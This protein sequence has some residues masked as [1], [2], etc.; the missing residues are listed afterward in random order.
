MLLGSG[1]PRA[2][3]T[4]PSSSGFASSLNTSTLP[5]RSSSTR[6]TKMK[7]RNAKLAK[8]AL[9]V[10][11]PLPV[12]EHFW[13]SVQKEGPNILVLDIETSPMLGM[14]FGMYDQSLSL[15]HVLQHSGIL[16]YCGMW[17]HD[18]EPFYQ[19]LRGRDPYDDKELVEQLW[20][21][22]DTCDVLVTINGKKFDVRKIHYR[23]MAHGLG[24]PRA[25]QHCDAQRLSKTYSM[26]DS[27]KLE[28]ISKVYGHSYK[29]GHG[30]F[31]GIELWRECLQDNIEAWKE[32]ETYNKQDVVATAEV[33]KKIR[34]WGYP[35]VDLSKFYKDQKRCVHCGSKQVQK[36]PGDI[37]MQANSYRQYRCA[38]CQGLLR[39]NRSIQSNK[40]DT[41]YVRIV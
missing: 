10:T 30:K 11:Q 18:G 36:V 34:G 39:G 1:V 19:D 15:K 5:I 3:S 21:L 27:H 29:E 20:T 32:M 38:G 12:P 9:V 40:E 7:T 26:P 23:A 35:G 33:Y 17:L 2:P 24:R 16:S 41:G 4:L 6:T 31:P 37:H 14:T 13:P 8:P 22:L 28:H 25:Y